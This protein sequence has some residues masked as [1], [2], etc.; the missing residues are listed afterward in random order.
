MEPL[1]QKWLSSAIES[2]DAALLLEKN[3]YRRSSASR[4][5]YAAY[6]AA[7][8]ILLYLEQ[9]PPDGREAWSHAATPD[10]LQRM[11]GSF[12]KQDKKNDTAARLADLYKLRIVADYQFE[13][14]MSNSDLDI[15]LKSASYTIRTI[16]GVMKARKS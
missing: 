14:G 5:Y 8:A 7:T 16:V 2:L 10:L 6:Q 12:W 3:G 4:G 11:P 15:A 1:W 9:V 13:R